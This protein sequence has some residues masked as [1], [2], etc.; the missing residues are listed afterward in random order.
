MGFGAGRGGAGPE[1]LQWE[2]GRLQL[3]GEGTSGQGGEGPSG[4][5][6][7]GQGGTGRGWA[8]PEQLQ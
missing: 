2:G 6:E 7:V 5:G 3:Q 4:Q 1:Q 8:G